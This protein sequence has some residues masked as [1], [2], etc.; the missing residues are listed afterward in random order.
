VGHKT[1]D[2][3]FFGYKIHIVMNEER[4]FTAAVITIGEKK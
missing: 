1:A 3:S 4:I 2:S